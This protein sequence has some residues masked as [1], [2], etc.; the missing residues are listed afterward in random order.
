MRG[1]RIL[2][3]LDRSILPGS[4]EWEEIVGKVEERPHLVV[5]RNGIIRSQVGAVERLGEGAMQP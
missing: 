4:E 5:L 1:A 3:L 2:L